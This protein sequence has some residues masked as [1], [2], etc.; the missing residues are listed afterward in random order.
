MAVAS[1]DSLSESGAAIPEI[2]SLIGIHHDRKVGLEGF[3]H[4]PKPVEVAP[5]LRGPDLDLHR[6]E[7]PGLVSGHFLNEF[8]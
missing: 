1:A 6:A 7:S 8:G 2:H 5:F 4:E 3:A